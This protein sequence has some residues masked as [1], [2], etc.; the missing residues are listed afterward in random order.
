MKY[1]R[2]CVPRF[3]IQMRGLALPILAYRDLML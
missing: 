3:R 1:D 2:Q